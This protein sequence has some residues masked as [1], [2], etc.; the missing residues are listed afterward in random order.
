[1]KAPS[2]LATWLLRRFG[3]G[4]NNQQVI[5]DLLEL[6]RKHESPLWYWRQVASAI[7]VSFFKAISGRSMLR[8]TR[9]AMLLS[10]IFAAVVTPTNDIPNMMIVAI[11]LMIFYFALMLVVM[12]LES[13]AA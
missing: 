9:W 11:P 12:F 8:R 1:M 4:P 2:R 10:T 7:A 6:Y 13:R 5:G 3:S